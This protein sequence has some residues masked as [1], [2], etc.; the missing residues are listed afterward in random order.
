MIQSVICAHRNQNVSRL[1]SNVLWREIGGLCQVEFIELRVRFSLL[2]GDLFRYLEN[3]KKD[4]REGHTGNR[5]YLL[6]KEIDHAQQEKGQ[7]DER[8]TDRN[9]RIAVL[10]VS[11]HL[12]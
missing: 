2:L 8:D 3:A 11:R 4:Q 5:S 1:H 9:F 10:E 12:K 6:G 7:S